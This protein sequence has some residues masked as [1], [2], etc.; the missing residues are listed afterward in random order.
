MKGSASKQRLQ[1]IKS[2]I[3]ALIRF[4]EAALVT[5]T[6]DD[7][8]KLLTK[9]MDL[10]RSMIIELIGAINNSNLKIRNLS[11]EIF[12]RISLLLSNY[13]ATHQLL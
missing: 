8:Q 1:L 6:E 9:I 13:K 10:I 12:L 2:Y 4:S 5:A 3:D 11:G 7:K